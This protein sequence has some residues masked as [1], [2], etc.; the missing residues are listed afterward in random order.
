MC[1]LN[2]LVRCQIRNILKLLR[3][4]WD[5]FVL[6]YWWSVVATVILFS[7]RGTA[8][9]DIWFMCLADKPMVRSYHLTD[10]D[11]TPLSQNPAWKA[12]MH[13]CPAGDGHSKTAVGLL[14]EPISDLTRARQGPLP[15][16]CI[17][18]F[19]RRGAKSFANDVVEDRGVV[20]TRPVFSLRFVESKPQDLS[21]LPPGTRAQNGRR[22]F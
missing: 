8:D 11:W 18:L 17:L 5:R 16:W 2:F 3:P 15:S 9:S 14:L 12:T 1:K 22:S 13:S 20:I 21:I 19:E 6:H 10:Y 7:T 4:S